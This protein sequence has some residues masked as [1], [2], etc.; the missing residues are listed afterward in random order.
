M[1]RIL[2]V[3]FWLGLLV[4]TLLA[5]SM[6][7]NWSVTLAG[8][9]F[10]SRWWKGRRDAARRGALSALDPAPVTSV[11]LQT[12]DASTSSGQPAIPKIQSRWTTGSVRDAHGPWR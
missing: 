11:A 12:A 8:L 1:L 9:Y 5:H 2:I 6:V 10:L 3:L 7:A 4:G